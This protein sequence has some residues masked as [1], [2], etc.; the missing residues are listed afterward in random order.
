MHFYELVLRACFVKN[1]DAKVKYPVPLFGKR[2][3]NG[4]GVTFC[5]N[6]NGKSQQAQSS[7]YNL[8]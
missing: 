1:N 4:H 7:G 2:Q 8:L 6:K 3:I 5:K